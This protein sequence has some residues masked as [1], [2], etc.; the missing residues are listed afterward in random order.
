MMKTHYKQFQIDLQSNQRIIVADGSK[1]G[2][3]QVGNSFQEFDLLPPTDLSPEQ[4]EQIAS[5]GRDPAEH[6]AVGNAIFPAAARQWLRDAYD[7]IG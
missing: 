2:L 6:C 5:F 7:A 3:R 1:V 4:S